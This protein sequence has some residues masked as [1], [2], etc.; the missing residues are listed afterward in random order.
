MTEEPGAL[1]PCLN[2]DPDGP[3]AIAS[4]MTIQ[5]I[6]SNLTNKSFVA[7]RADGSLSLSGIPQTLFERNSQQFAHLV[8]V[9]T[10][11]GLGIGEPSDDYVETEGAWTFFAQTL[12]EDMEKKSEAQPSVRYLTKQDLRSIYKRVMPLIGAPR[13]EVDAATAALMPGHDTAA[14]A[15]L[16]HQAA[17]SAQMIVGTLRFDQPQVG[18]GRV[19]LEDIEPIFTQFMNAPQGEED[20]GRFLR[21]IRASAALSARALECGRRIVAEQTINGGLV[22]RGIENTAGARLAFAGLLMHLHPDVLREVMFTPEQMRYQ[23]AVV[24]M[25]LGRVN[26]AMTGSDPNVDAAES[27]GNQE[28]VVRLLAR[29]QERFLELPIARPIVSRFNESLG[30]LQRNSA[31]FE[32]LADLA[33]ELYEDPEF[34]GIEAERF[35]A[36]LEDPDFAQLLEPSGDLPQESAA[37]LTHIPESALGAQYAP[38]AAPVVVPASTDVKFENAPGPT[39]GPQPRARRAS[40]REKKP[41]A[42]SAPRAVPRSADGAAPTGKDRKPAQHHH[43]AHFSHL[44]K[45]EVKARL[46]AIRAANRGFHGRS[47]DTVRDFKAMVDAKR[48]E[49]R[50]RMTSQKLVQPI[51]VD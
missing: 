29:N 20:S 6:A 2:M 17:L 33:A 46:L 11:C 43:P 16:R 32:R 3:E 45:A 31:R 19:S 5:A 12:L 48:Q 44:K 42:A 35:L 49:R 39:A 37:C 25:L 38:S 9:I 1:T 14:V 28:E 22:D 26:T 50:N 40:G 23:I 36:I 21:A 47:E 34:A 51:E 24:H 10:R 8:K 13:H 41:I 27:V 18:E 7:I 15:S 4:N 30:I